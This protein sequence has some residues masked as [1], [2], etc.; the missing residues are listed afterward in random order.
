[1]SSHPIGGAEIRKAYL[2]FFAA[3]AHTV[4]PSASLIPVDP[5][6]LLTVAGMVPFKPY[7]LGDEP[8]PYPRATTSQKCIRTVD[9]DIV[10]T[11]ARHLSFFEMLGNFSFGDYFKERAIPWAYEFSTEVLGF[12]P[13]RL[14]FTVHHS[15]DDAAEI[16]IDKV[17][18][19]ANRV[20]RRDRDNFWQMGVAGPAG[21]CSELFYDRGPEFGVD[22]GPVADEER[23][24]EFWNLVF[25]QYVQDVPYHVVGDLPAKSIDTGSGLERV[26]VL[27]QG[28]DNV[29]AT[30]LLHPV[31]AAGEAATGVAFGTSAAGDVSLRILADH[32]RALTFL[33][34]DG[35]VPSNE[36]RGYILRRLLRRAVRHAWQ[37]GAERPVTP[38]LVDATIEVM[39]PGYPAL[40]SGRDGIVEMAEREELRFRRTLESGHTLLASELE[41]MDAG[42]VLAGPTAF[43]LHDT[44]GFPVE[45]TEEIAA[46]RG[47]TVDRDGFDA[48]MAAQR[49][50]GRAAR[51]KPGAAEG[52]PLYRSILDAHGATPFLGYEQLDLDAEV[53]AIIRDGELVREAPAGAE[54]EVFF[55][56]TTFYGESGGQIGDTGS[57]T[58][59]TGTVRI[60]DTQLPV[61]GLHGHKGSIESGKIAVGQ[62]AMLSVD[63]GRRERI[64]KSHTGT[65]ILHSALREIVGS[66]VQQ[67]GSLVEAGRLRFDFSHFS[68]LDDDQLLAVEHLANERVIANSAVRAYQVARAEAEEM[69]ALAFFGDKYG[70]QVRIVEAGSYSRELCGGTHV[71]T[72]GQIGPLIVVA[73]SSI[74]S[75]LR[76]I[77]AFTGSSGYEYLTGLRRQLE[78][79]AGVLRVRPD[80]VGSAAATLVARTRAQEER[81]E[82]FEEQSRS[83]LAADIA[84]GAETVGRGRLVVA[85]AAGFNP[86]ALRLL[87]MQVR[88]RLGTGIAILGS[89]RDSKAGLV[90]VV[91]ADLVADGVSAAAVVG[92]A[93]R[94]VG[95][96]A[97]RDTAL[98]QAGGP[99]GDRLGDALA[100]A[101]RAAA[102]ALGG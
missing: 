56:G 84:A 39:S 99:H 91:T 88:D 100:E 92:P 50:R 70:E 85:E 57:A 81:I 89:L 90:A 11:T 30:D 44:F 46:E 23:F 66:H 8:A 24:M 96:G 58:T 43:K 34:A 12:D 2:E 42:G 17:G 54:V 47:L 64:R 35:V 36:G 53:L 71:P 19:P 15:D 83:R 86:E 52:S 28:V 82:A 13:E 26:A 67:A 74:G 94:V 14:W 33:I 93:A 18:V 95:G 79:A 61:A 37:L 6:L 80:E 25:M 22:G 27:T 98:S 63:A 32:G 87:A 65:H 1:M 31:L 9:I 76:R 73:E 62:R 51:A 101:R 10:G 55:A 59:E 29:F 7:L 60:T 4:V 69:G 48:E 77:E 41:G 72:T 21:P 38:Y 5:T 75:N 40:R 45:L 49:E 102:A 78:T 97:S 16:W 68:A 20:Q 3:R